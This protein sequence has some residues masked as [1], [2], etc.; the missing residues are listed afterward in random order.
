MVID[1][2]KLEE[3]LEILLKKF[4]NN[5]EILGK[6]IA[7]AIL[8]INIYGGDEKV[9]AN[10]VDLKF[11]G[12]Q[13]PK[14]MAPQY[15]KSG[16]EAKVKRMGNQLGISYTLKSYKGIVLNVVI[17]KTYFKIEKIFEDETN[18]YLAEYVFDDNSNFT[19]YA[20]QKSAPLGRLLDFS[21]VSEGNFRRGVCYCQIKESFQEMQTKIIKIETTKGEELYYS[22]FAKPDLFFMFKTPAY[23]KMVPCITSLGMK[24]LNHLLEKQFSEDFVRINNEKTFKNLESVCKTLLKGK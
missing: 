9:V 1:K 13:P 4:G 3:K 19:R 18:Y 16:S 20:K 17:S 8:F 14:V 6:D 12:M 15:N 22:Y 21:E 23:I 2:T 11:Y 24:D 5:I 7:D 10:E